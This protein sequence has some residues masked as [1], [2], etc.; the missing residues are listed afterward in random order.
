MAVETRG[1]SPFWVS[2]AMLA[3]ALAVAFVAL[4]LGLFGLLSAVW[5]LLACVTA[6][7]LTFGGLLHGNRTARRIR[8]GASQCSEPSSDRS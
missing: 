1:R 2:W 4:L 5:A 8:E 7:A 3:L 6:W